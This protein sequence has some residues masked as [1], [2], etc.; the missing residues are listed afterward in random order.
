MTL[1]RSDIDIT[2]TTAM[3]QD[4]MCIVGRSAGYVMSGLVILFL[5]VDG[6]MKL[7]PL[8]VVTETMGQ[9]GYRPSV[10]RNLGILTIVCTVLYAIPKT[11][12]LGA[13]LLTG[14]LGGAIA[15]HLRVDS[16]IFTHLLFGVY[17]GLMVW[18]GLFLRDPKVRALIPLRR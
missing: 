12:V 1:A 8:D 9:L 4:S 5:L 18:G 2:G 6:V 15:T 17:L 13:I 14:L 3:T 16:P 10:A 11:A 7:I